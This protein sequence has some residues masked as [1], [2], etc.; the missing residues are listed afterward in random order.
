MGT[1]IA[2]ALSGII[3]QYE[4][5]PTVFYIFGGVGLLWFVLWC[6]LC[7]NDPSSHPFISEEEKAYLL[8]TIG[9]TKRKDVSNSSAT[10]QVIDISR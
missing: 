8:E 7:Y 10:I 1:V 6:V 2:S 3:L 5:W 4:G 9:E